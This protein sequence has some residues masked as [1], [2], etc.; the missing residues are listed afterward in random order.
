M[1]KPTLKQPTDQ[2]KAFE[3]NYKVTNAKAD[4]LIETNTLLNEKEHS[5]KKKIFDLFL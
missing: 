4:T 1:E 3:K 2:G 5:L